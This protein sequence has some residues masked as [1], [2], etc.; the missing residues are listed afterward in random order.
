MKTQYNIRIDSLNA[1]EL[2]ELDSQFTSLG[3]EIRGIND[4]IGSHSFRIYQWESDELPPVYP[5][6]Y[7]PRTEL[8]PIETNYFP[9]PVDD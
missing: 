4:T 6:E 8:T 2:L 1:E 3:W 7:E 9:R 5:V